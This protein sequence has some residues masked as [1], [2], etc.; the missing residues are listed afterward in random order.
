MHAGKTRAASVLIRSLVEKGYRVGAAKLTGVALRRD[1]LEM[2]DGPD[3]QGM[4]KR[5]VQRAAR[6]L[7]R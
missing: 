7:S 1:A 6:C 5:I 4:P 3:R 2:Q